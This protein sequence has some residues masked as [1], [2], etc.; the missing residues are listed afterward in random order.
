MHELERA[1]GSDLGDALVVVLVDDDHAHRGRS[2]APRP[3]R[4]SGSSSSVRAR[5]SRRRGRTTEAPATRAVGYGTPVPTAP[6]V[7]ALLAVHDGEAYVRAG[8]REHPRPDRR[9]SRARRRRRRVD[10]TRTPEI[11]AGIDD[12]RLRVLR[13]DEQLGLAGSL[14][15]GL[16]EARGTYVARLDADDVAMPRR[17]ERQLARFAREPAVPA[18][19]G[20]A[21]L[22]LD[23][24]ARRDAARDARR[25]DSTCAGPRSSARP[26][27]H[28]TVLVERDVLER[29]A[30]RYDT[31][32]D[33]SEDYDLWSRLLDVADGDNVAGAARPLPRPP[34]AGVAAAA[35]APARVPAARRAPRRSRSVAPEL[36]ARARWSS[37]GASAS[38]S[39]SRP[40][41]SRRSGRRVPRAC[42]RRSSDASE[43]GARRGAAARALVRLAA[44]HPGR[45]TAPR[46]PARRFGSTRSAGSRSRPARRVG[47]SRLEHAAR[48]RRWLRRLA[49]DEPPAPSASRRSSRSRR[50]TARRSSTGSRR[51]RRSTS[52]SSTRPTPSRA[53]PGASSRSTAPSSS[54]GSASRARSA[55]CTTTTRSRPASSARSTDARPDVVVVSGWSTFAAQAAI[56][57]CGSEGR[58]VRARRREPRRR[59]APRMAAHG[60]GDGRAADRRSGRLGLLVTGTLARDSMIARGAHPER[61]HVFANTIDVE[62]FG[63]QR[64]S[65]RRPPAGAAAR[66]RRGRRGRGRA[67]GRTARAGEGARRARPRGGGG[68]R[69]AARARRSP[70]KAPSARA[71]RALARRSSACGSSSPGDVDWERIV[72]LYV[73]ADVF[74]L[75][76][77]REPWAVVV[78]EAA[79]CGLPLVLSDR[80][81]A[82]HDLLRDGENGVL[83]GR[84]RRRC[85]GDGAPRA[86]RRPGAPARAGRPLARARGR[87]GLRTERRG[88]PRGGAGG[89]RRS[90]ASLS[91]VSRQR[92]SR[93]QPVLLARR[94]GDR[95]P[96]D[97]AL[98]GARRGLRRRGRHGRPARPRGRAAADR[99]Q[100]RPHHARRRPR[101]TSAPSSGGGRRTTS[102]ISDRRSG[103]R[104]PGPHPDLVVCMTDP[105]IIGDL[106]VLVG[107]R[108]GAPVLVISQDVFPEIATELDRL[109]NPAVI[110]VLRGLVGAYL[111]RADR[112]V[113]IGETMR[114]RL[115]AKGAPPERLR[116]IPNWVDTRAITPQPRDNEWAASARSGR[117]LR[118][119][120]LGQRRA[121]AGPRQP[122][123]LGDVPARPR[124]PAHRH[125]R[126]RRAARRDGRARGAARGRRRPFASFRTRSARAFRSRSRARTSTS[127]ASPRASRATSSRAGCTGSSRRAAP[128]SSPPRTRARPRGSSARSD[129]AS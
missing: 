48:P 56:A 97:R 80:V 45:G 60:Q 99:A 91:R 94:R 28:P 117:S 93:P 71:L 50:R 29:H 62:A 11:L 123:S 72:E 128:S 66:A 9:G 7:T 16:D 75:L 111:R 63:E 127:S 39:T 44:A 2:P 90:A 25:G 108:V 113:A 19:V 125:R 120:A 115:E 61:V 74:A 107:K 122:R 70:A 23:E 21:V 112:I 58:A 116:V 35:R 51:T 5:P 32:F 47:A 109:R 46:S 103:T 4:G 30:L 98:R 36:V 54:A 118:R 101:R 87:L 81:G 69:S 26:F 27:F 14:N 84:R 88:I 53:G 104:S 33:E 52:R 12:A 43:R 17:L 65:A 6:L 59:A 55:S 106:G 57:W 89:S 42:R 37:R 96:P 24:R 18:V 1:P 95:A 34:R 77:E 49:G 22:E 129:A 119:H 41:R 126:L 79:A 20:S 8:A 100:R 92:D 73:A 76:S 85:R 78:N 10:A 102:R 124:R 110:G 67:L 64:R 121:R 15:R 114:E 86:R 31:G 38:P 82:A 3:S 13:N 105:P 68:R 40:R 83:V